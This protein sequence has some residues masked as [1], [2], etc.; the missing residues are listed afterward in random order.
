MQ[1]RKATP[2]ELKQ[3]MEQ[4]MAAQERLSKEATEEPIEDIPGS[5][6][7]VAQGKEPRLEDA[8]EFLDVGSEG[9][10]TSRDAAPSQQEG[11][12]AERSSPKRLEDSQGSKQPPKTPK[13]ISVSAPA[14]QSSEPAASV[15]QKPGAESVSGKGK[16][17][18]RE[19]KTGQDLA[20]DTPVRPPVESQMYI[21]GF[22]SGPDRSHMTTPLFSA[23]QLREW[24][25]LHSRAP[26]LYRLTPGVQR[27][28]WLEEEER[29]SRLLQE[30]RAEE[31]ERA[32]RLQR[33][34]EVNE[35]RRRL[36]SLEEENLRLKM[37]R[38]N[39]QQSIAQPKG[40]SYGNPGD[41]DAEVFPKEAET[42]KE[43]AQTPREDQERKLQ[44]TMMHSM[45]KL[46][47]GMQ[48]MQA[49]ILD[50]RRQKDVEVVKNAAVE[51]PKLQEWKADTAPLDLADWLLVV[52]PVLSDLSD[53]SQ[54]W[55]EAMLASVRQWYAEHQEKTPLERV[56]HKPQVP[57]PLQDPR[58]QRL[59][60]RATALLMSAIPPTQQEEVVASKEVNTVGILSQLMLCYQPGGLSEKGAILTALDS[61]EEAPSLARA[62]TGLRRWLRWHRRAGEV[63][64][65][66]PDATLQI[67]GLGRLMKRVLKDNADLAFRVQV[68]RS[69]LQV[70]TAPTEA[71]V[72]TF[73][74]HLLAEVEQIAHQDKRRKE[75]AKSS[76]EPKVKRLEEFAGGSK[77]EGKAWRGEGAQSSTPCKFFQSEE[78]CKKG[79][80]CTWSHVLEGEKG[81][82]GGEGK[83]F[84]KPS[85]KALKKGESQ[86]KEEGPGGEATSEESATSAE[87]MKGLLEEANRILKGL[88]AR[89][90]EAESR[91]K[92]ERLTA[93]QGQLDELRKLKVLRLSRI[94]KEQEAYGLL[95]SGATNPMR[96]KRRGED[97]SQL[98]EVQVTLADG[99]QVGMKMT[100]SGV[101]VVEDE[102]A[103]PI[104]PLC[105]LTSKLGYVASWK[106]G[107][108]T[109][110]HPIDGKVEVCMRS[111]CPQVSRLD[112]LR[113]IQKLEE[114]ETPRMQALKLSQEEMWLWEL[115]EAHPVLKRLPEAIKRR[116]VVKP[117]EDLRGIPDANRRRRRVMAEQGFV[118]H[119]YAGESAGYSLSRAF[120]EA[121]G[122]GRRLVEIDVKRENHEKH[123][124][125]AHDMLDDENGPFASLLR[126]ALDGSLLGIVMGPNC[127][128]GLEQPA[129]PTHYIPEVVTLWKTEEWELLRRMYDLK[130]Q[131]FKQSAWGGRA[132]KPTTFAGNVTLRLP[133]EDQAES[134]EESA[135]KAQ[136]MNSVELSRWPPGMMKE[137]A[138]R[139]QQDVLQAK[140]KAAKMSCAEHLE[141]GH[142]PFRRDCRVC[143]EASARGRM[144]SKVKHPRAGVMSLDVT[145][146]YKKG[147]DIDGEAK[148]MLI[149]TYTW[150]RPPDEEEA[151]EV[152]EELELE[153]QEDEDQWPEIE[154][155]EAAQEE[156]EEEEEEEE[157]ADAAEDPQEEQQAEPPRAFEEPPE[158][159]K[160]EVM[161]I[162][163]PIKGKAQEAVLSGFIELYLQLKEPPPPKD[164]M[165]LAIAEEVERD[166]I[167]ERRRIREK[168]PIRDGGLEGLLGIRRMIQEEAQSV[169]MDQLDNALLTFQ[170][171]DPWKKVMK[172]AEGAEQEILQTKI[173]SPQELVK[174]VHLWDEAI[175]AELDALLNAK[176][177]L[178]KITSE[179]KARLEERHPDLLVVPSKLVITRKAG[180][181]R[182]VRIV[183]CGNYVEKTEKED[184]FA[185][186]SDSISFRIALKKSL[187][188]GWTGAT[189]DI[190]TAFLNAPLGR[191]AEALEGLWKK[192]ELE[193]LGQEVVV[194]LVK[195][196][197]L[198]IKLGYI[199]PEDWWVAVKAVYGLR[200]SPKAWGDHRALVQSTTDPNVWKIVKRSGGLDEEMEGLCVVY[201]DDLM[202]LSQE[203]IV[204]ECL[205]RISR[206]WE[207][208]TPEW[209]NE[210]KPVKFLG[211]EVLMGTKSAFITQESY[212]QDLLRRNGEEEGHKSGIPISKDQVL[213][214]EE[215]DHT[216]SPEDVKA[217]QRATGELMWLVTRSRPDLMFALSKMSRATLKN[218]KEVLM[219]AK[220]VWKYL[221]KTKAEG[222]ELKAG[223]KDLEVYT[224]SSYGSGGLD[225]QGTVL[226]LWGKSP[227]MW[228]SGRQGA[229]A[230]STA[231]SELTEGIDGMIMGDSVDVLILELSQD[232][233]AK[234][235]KID[236]TAAV[237]LM[238]EAAG[239]WRTRHL[240][241]RASHL[242]WRIGRLDWVVE[243]ISGQVQIADIGTK[244]L[245]APRL[246]ELK[247]MMGMKQR[248]DDQEEEKQEQKDSGSRQHMKKGVEETGL[249]EAGAEVER[250]LRMVILLCS[251][252]QA[253]AQEQEEEEGWSSLA[254]LVA[255]TVFAMIGV[256]TCISWMVR[257]MTPAKRSLEEEELTKRV[258]EALSTDSSQ[259]GASP[260]QESSHRRTAPTRKEQG[261]EEEG[262]RQQQ[263]AAS[264]TSGAHAP[265]EPASSS[266]AVP[267]PQISV[268]APP[269]IPKQA[270]L[271]APASTQHQRTVPTMSGNTWTPGE[272]RGQRAVRGSI[273]SPIF[274][275][276]WGA[277]YH[278][279]TSCPT[280]ANTKRFVPC[281]WCDVCAPLGK[282]GDQP[283]YTCGPGSKAHYDSDCVAMTESGRKYQKC[284]RCVNAT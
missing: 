268:K 78:G 177:A 109:L 126:S 17:T 275:T 61:P 205:E 136:V 62:V 38:E 104:V 74:N 181:R 209:L 237:S 239:S 23:Q 165:W 208:S 283:V 101:M 178:R 175:K 267:P 152:D 103:E 157:Q 244:A 28:V 281:Q 199:S 151:T 220:Q 125:G 243:A 95:D 88:S 253:K 179:E 123:R 155:Q 128:L 108:M 146:P 279:Y 212:V 7:D 92:D 71:S 89:T 195:P 141:R 42:T 246:E 90:G 234:V 231:E 116:L 163:I 206:E 153:A 31:E 223:G 121:G 129:D 255:L 54:Q 154:D 97:L 273:R 142:T 85:G 282:T 169:E 84:H 170:K 64:V 100:A 79:K 82:K 277:R 263:T 164:E 83:G 249:Q 211:M 184:V 140:L 185:S 180:G 55:W 159:P 247:Q 240:R 81:Q 230:L 59:E 98:E 236:N 145:G 107:R 192:E 196:P 228:K 250:I 26:W 183:A 217:A 262:G 110:S 150:L 172:R 257:L 99:S 30:E 2:E 156:E 68:S 242:R 66:R 77:G 261:H 44:A 29:R 160:I 27:P 106:K 6:S 57:L 221:R 162:G 202:V 37:E 219:V 158:P 269:P 87:T 260:T 3:G 117:A 39:L 118:V 207:I 280:L 256:T 254:Q 12:K 94:G 272:E 8:K 22:E 122:D 264:S 9:I 16:G 149:G 139:I 251:V 276:P 33:E 245:T 147:K 56:N 18:K 1:R 233:Y 218:P 133:E 69:S 224:D 271:P 190:R 193:E 131:S 15:A 91:T 114:V 203:H 119:L 148:F 215:E 161:R 235:I 47:E 113:M 51:L 284:Q 166:E 186:G 58:F 176:E 53:N 187:D 70:D 11:Q 48:T 36:Q 65:T 41:K 13:R 40:S 124:K 52:E 111:G 194:V 213:R 138:T 266:Q 229:P 14:A 34:A 127:R 67:K 198:L 216:K 143:Q 214:L 21:A 144:H 167:Q 45:V 4:M 46:M 24:E 76:A 86:Q 204:K 201:V 188:E 259:R 171:M 182:K 112:A 270:P 132:V 238:T 102:W 93:M 20:C 50:V 135:A 197:A 5:H 10:E 226:V 227:I 225:S 265:E 35:M 130:A 60:K 63:G 168:R 75:D 96:G 25:E 252:Q 173:V 278:E 258:K 191:S 248:R 210:V 189:A 72:M 137:V 120:K 134:F 105:L 49:Q 73:A 19:E 174:D 222:L 274:V 232:T 241:L 43:E 32:R 115:M 80:Q 200:Q